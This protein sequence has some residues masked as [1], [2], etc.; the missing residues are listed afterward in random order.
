MAVDKARLNLPQFSETT[1]LVA[2]TLLKS[3]VSC[4]TKRET[5]FKINCCTSLQLFPVPYSHCVV[6]T[7]LKLAREPVF[8]PRGRPRCA[9]P[10]WPWRH[11]G[12]A[13]AAALPLR[14]CLLA[15]WAQ[16]LPRWNAWILEKNLIVAPGVLD[17]R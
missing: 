15:C 7:P 6:K 11:R 4:L 12:S 5:E 10:S 3:S 8:R 17:R 9:E 2:E 13:R 14:S 1:T 16:R